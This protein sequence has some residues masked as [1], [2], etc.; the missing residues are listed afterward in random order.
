LI[1]K[2]EDLFRINRN[3][4]RLYDIVRDNDDCTILMLREEI[5]HGKALM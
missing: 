4:L 5:I 3:M 2:E 1:E